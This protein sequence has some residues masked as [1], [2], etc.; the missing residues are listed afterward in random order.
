MQSESQPHAGEERALVDEIK[1]VGRLALRLVEDANRVD[2]ACQEAWLRLRGVGEPLPRRSEI[3]RTLRRILSRERRADQRRS[4]R[5]ERREQPASEE[6]VDVLLARRE[7]L[8]RVWDG[9]FALP[10]PLRST[11]LLHFQEGLTPQ[12]IAERQGCPP[13]T[14]RWR[15]RTGI[16]RLRRSL[17]EDREG[18]GLAGLLLAPPL[19]LGGIDGRALLASARGASV[20]WIGGLLMMKSYLAVATAVL[21]ACWFAWPAERASDGAE[22]ALQSQFA[23]APAQ[24]DDTPVPAPLVS[25]PSERTTVSQSPALDRIA[26]LAPVEVTPPQVVLRL[27]LERHDDLPLAGPVDVSI[28]SRAGTGAALYEKAPVR[29]GVVELEASPFF[30]NDQDAQEYSLEVRA[31]G[32]A[33]GTVSSFLSTPGVVQ[34]LRVPMRAVHELSVSLVDAV[35]GVALASPRCEVFG[36][37]AA[38]GGWSGDVERERVIRVRVAP[39]LNEDDWLL[40]TASGYAPAPRRLVD[41][42]ATPASADGVRDVP[43]QRGATLSGWIERED[44]LPLDGEHRLEA[45][46]FPKFSAAPGCTIPASIAARQPIAVRPDG[47]FQIAGLPE[48][49]VQLT[50]LRRSENLLQQPVMEP[51]KTSVPAEGQKHLRIAVPLDLVTVTVDIDW[52]PASTEDGAQYAQWLELYRLDSDSDGPYSASPGPRRQIWKTAAVQGQPTRLPIP[53]E[54][55]DSNTPLLLCIGPDP[56]LR[57]ERWVEFSGPAPTLKHR[58]SKETSAELWDPSSAGDSDAQVSSVAAE[59]RRR[60]SIVL[61]AQ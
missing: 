31:A 55:V 22:V 5:E 57:V 14:I 54:L 59:L 18:G 23:S 11:L 46:Y 48:G 52:R 51:V 1:W 58:F 4:Q 24:V 32:W 21:L 37:G 44:G 15:L 35:T 40:F 12:A 50:L 8:Q 30:P 47:T 20:P 7:Q 43:M 6:A 41:L 19:S 61:R 9:V 42:L 29:D 36:P 3:L 49:D 38:L 25:M 56:V 27:R 17:G 45:R 53:R 39:A 60:S 2:D 34:E 13:D 28:L 16:S 26:L 33:P 10:E